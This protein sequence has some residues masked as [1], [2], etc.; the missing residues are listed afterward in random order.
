MLR[1]LLNSIFT[2]LS[3]PLQATQE[4]NPD[5]YALTTM[6]LSRRGYY[7]TQLQFIQR[8]YVATVL[9][10]LPEHS[11]IAPTIIN[12]NIDE[13]R[14]LAKVTRCES[15]VCTFF[16]SSSSF[17]V[18]LILLLLFLF[19]QDIKFS[20]E[21]NGE[22]VFRISPSGQILLEHELD[23]EKQQEYNLEVYVTDGNF[24]SICRVDKA[25]GLGSVLGTC[26]LVI[27]SSYF[28]AFKFC[29]L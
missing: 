11:V 22:G 5:R 28:H 14:T 15:C 2:N 16:S 21:R 6:T 3:P 1:T 8:D 20:L 4:D 7:S 18:P 26:K 27:H 29:C 13:V 23:F 17:D 25:L 19:P 10:N 9:E 12:K 24:V